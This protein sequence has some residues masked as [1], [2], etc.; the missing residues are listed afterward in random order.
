ML[1][2]I[3]QGRANPSIAILCRL[4]ASLRMSVEDLVRVEERRPDAVR[5]MEADD[6]RVLWRGAKGGS[7]SL[8][9]GSEGPDM[10]ELWRWTL[11]AG[12]RFESQPHGAGTLELLTVTRGTLALEV[13]GIVHRVRAG[14]SLAARTDRAHSY[15]CFGRGRTAFTMVVFEKS[16]PER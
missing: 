14:S 9:V 12:D 4:A 10:L 11:F 8:L 7:A 2:V 16:P 5:V 3:E 1:V 6:A 13:E 15:A